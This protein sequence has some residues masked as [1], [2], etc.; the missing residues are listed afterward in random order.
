MA[1]LWAR[2]FWNSGTWAAS[3]TNTSYYDGTTEASTSSNAAFL[4]APGAITFYRGL[5]QYDYRLFNNTDSTDVGTPL[6]AQNTAATLAA[7]GAAF[8]LRML[9]PTLAL[10]SHRRRPRM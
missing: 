3:W 5:Y 8:R 2:D 6:A 4:Q 1:E 7:T 10:R 9:L